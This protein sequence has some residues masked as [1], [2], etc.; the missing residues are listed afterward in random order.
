MHQDVCLCLKFL[1]IKVVKGKGAMGLIIH[2]VGFSDQGITFPKAPAAFPS[3]GLLGQNWVTWTPHYPSPAKG[4]GSAVTGQDQSQS[5]PWSWALYSRTQARRQLQKK[6]GEGCWV[7]SQQ[8]LPHM[9][10][11]P[12]RSE[13]QSRPG[14]SKGNQLLLLGRSRV[15]CAKLRVDALLPLQHGG[16]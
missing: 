16:K 1:K 11:A 5:S 8:R 4:G 2:R 15:C 3:S 13:R 12:R 6:M 7:G 9:P 10:S 14:P